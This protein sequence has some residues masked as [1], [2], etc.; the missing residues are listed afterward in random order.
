MRTQPPLNVNN[1]GWTAV[2]AGI[3][4]REIRLCET[5]QAGT[6][7]YLVAAP[8]NADGPITV[9][10]GERYPLPAPMPPGVFLKDQ[11]VCYLKTVSGSVTFD[12][13]EL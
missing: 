12:V 8:T 7:D 13:I 9:P 1:A 3:T 11:I 4:C 6:T 5:N 10:A 2:T